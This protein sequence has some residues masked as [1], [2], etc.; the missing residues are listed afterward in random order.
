MTTL[1]VSHKITEYLIGEKGI[2]GLRIFGA[3]L[4][5]ALCAYI[6][7]PLHPVPLSL[8][9]AGVMLVGVFLGS[10]GAVAAVSL[11]LFE[12]ALGLPVF[13]GGGAGLFTLFGVKAGYFAGFL[14]QA[15]LVGSFFERRSQNRASMTFFTLFASSVFSMLLGVF[16]LGRCIGTEAAWT[17]G[18]SIFLPGELV[19]ALA[20]AAYV[21]RISK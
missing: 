12:G 8:Q 14:L 1:V 19:K 15:F 16:W 20:V 21:K 11:Y 7:V 18:F 17:L 2:S 9:T 13:A 4:F 5:L 6:S 3:S 10:R